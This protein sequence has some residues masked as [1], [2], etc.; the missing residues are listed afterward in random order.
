MVAPR[1]HF[2]RAL[3]LTTAKA[4]KRWTLYSSRAYSLKASRIPR[5]PDATVTVTFTV[6]MCSMNMRAC[7]VCTW[8]EAGGE[9]LASGT[10]ALVPK[11]RVAHDTSLPPPAPGAGGGRRAERSSSGSLARVHF[12]KKRNCHISTERGV[13]LRGSIRSIPAFS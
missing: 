10:K 4:R 5:A 8:F 1:S 6:C 7:L 13:S 2:R 9:N 12:R 3:A 11:V